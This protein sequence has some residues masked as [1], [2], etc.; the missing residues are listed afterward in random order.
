M[1]WKIRKEKSE[2]EFTD[3]IAMQD[4][5]TDTDAIA[6]E[7]LRKAQYETSGEE[8]GFA[9]DLSNDA[10]STDR[11]RT[12]F[13]PA[14]PSWNN[15]NSDKSAF[16]LD[17]P[18]IN[19]ND[20][21]PPSDISNHDDSSEVT[22]FNSNTISQ[23]SESYQDP[24]VNNRPVWAMD[25]DT[26]STGSGFTP[27]SN[28]TPFGAP[29]QNN[30]PAQYTPEPPSQPSSNPIFNPASYQSQIN[31]FTPAPPPP[32]IP[33]PDRPFS[34]PSYPSQTDP[35]LPPAFTSSQAP[36]FNTPAYDPSPVYNPPP[37]FNQGLEP[38]NTFTPSFD[39]SPA[40]STFTPPSNSITPALDPAPGPSPFPPAYVPPPS[41]NKQPEPEPSYKPA[42]LSQPAQAEQNDSRR[43]SMASGLVTGEG[44]F[45][46]P[47]V[48][49]FI[50]SLPE[51]DTVEK[52]PDQHTLVIRMRNFSA[53]YTIT[54][55]VTTIGRPDSATQNYPDV[56][57]ELDDGVSRKHA[58]I[59]F[60]NGNYY[61]VDI[62]STN[63]SLLNGDL[64][65]PDV[66]MKLNHGDR[67]RV[68]EKTE[69]L[70]E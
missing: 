15:N 19:R 1:G 41:V 45:S 20:S 54:K 18:V 44:A 50:V 68:G 65:E 56:E 22:F 4:N 70:F 3:D 48:A 16:S 53:S 63:G 35:L 2:S 39:T 64:L 17:S 25:Q 69:I 33:P 24:Y 8:N 21:V 66:E 58:E 27:S 61:V 36:A 62:G 12:S 60:K 30:T 7:R 32:Y 5:D 51:S 46:I 10:F 9:F 11:S 42:Y 49:P 13:D 57:I 43:E 40:S 6:I 55:D 38:N 29:I 14:V 37:A 31:N 28:A 23:S 34:Q 59:R 26:D 67:I 47:K 52:D